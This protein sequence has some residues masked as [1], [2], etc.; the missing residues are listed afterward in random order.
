VFVALDKAYLANFVHPPT[1]SGRFT[2]LL[3]MD[4][5]AAAMRYK[6]YYEGNLPASLHRYD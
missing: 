5:N 3:V 1:F 6:A 2:I 4:A